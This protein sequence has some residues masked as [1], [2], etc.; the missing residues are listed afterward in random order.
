MNQSIEAVAP[1]IP[2][3]ELQVRVAMTK[4]EQVV[5]HAENAVQSLSKR[6]KPILACCPPEAPA[7]NKEQL[8][9]VQLAVWLTQMNHRIEKL[10]QFIEEMERRTEL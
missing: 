1:E 7:E 8:G 5:E 2:Q 6:I 10:A 3:R 9:G 4:Q